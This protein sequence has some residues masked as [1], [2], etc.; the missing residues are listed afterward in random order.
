[1]IAYLTFM[2]KNLLAVLLR[3]YVIVL[4]GVVIVPYLI[5]EKT[6]PQVAKS[7]DDWMNSHTDNVAQ[8]VWVLEG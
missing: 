8:L 4:C 5:A 3:L 7:I 1:M 2:T 6:A